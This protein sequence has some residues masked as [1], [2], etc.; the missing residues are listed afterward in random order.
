MRRLARHPFTLCSA[1]SLLL[2]VAVCVLWVRSYSVG[3]SFRVR[4]LEVG[5]R[6]DWEHDFSLTS[7][8]G[9]LRV[10]WQ[11]DP[12][13]KEPR[14]ALPFHQT[15]APLYAPFFGTL[16]LDPR[17]DRRTMLQKLGFDTE[18][19]A[20]ASTPPEIIRGVVG[21][22]WAWAVV[23]A[24]APAV[25]IRYTYTSRKRLRRAAAGNCPTCGYDLRASRE[26]CPECGTLTA[27]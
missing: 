18:W 17:R 12:V 16:S 23:F 22:H 7:A 27:A 13:A 4:H 24:I 9:G 11:I 26:R 1:V 5:P 19:S 8:R 3:D 15:Y 6:F 21:P 14:R 20:N 25:A 10:K 2:C